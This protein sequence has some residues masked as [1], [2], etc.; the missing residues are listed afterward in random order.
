MGLT[1]VS[2]G[3]NGATN[4]RF[5]PSHDIGCFWPTLVSTAMAY[6]AQNTVDPAMAKYLEDNK[7]KPI[8]TLPAFVAFIRGMERMMDPTVKQPAD[9]LV[10]SGFFGFSPAIQV[11][12]IYQIGLASLGGWFGSAK[13]C[14]AAGTLQD[15]LLDLMRVG[16]GIIEKFAS[17]PESSVASTAN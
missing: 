1:L 8:N 16:G 17:R 13:E 7:L 15:E 9:A 6:M 5:S 4:R 2:H 10:A 11:A 3:E 12:V 14:T